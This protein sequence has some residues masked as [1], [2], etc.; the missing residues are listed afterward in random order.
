MDINPNNAKPMLLDCFNKTKA[1]K[2]L[3][4]T[5]VFKKEH[6]KKKSS[7]SKY[8]VDMFRRTVGEGINKSTNI[9][10]RSE[11]KGYFN[12]SLKSIIHKIVNNELSKR[13]LGT[14][15]SKGKS[16]YRLQAPQNPTG[17]SVRK[18]QK[19]KNLSCKSER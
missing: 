18:K 1:I 6:S 13:T 12:P 14:S 4:Q 10:V 16:P 17:S 15:F 8:E 11:R 5:Q 9:D 7:S 2:S 3:Q 19:K